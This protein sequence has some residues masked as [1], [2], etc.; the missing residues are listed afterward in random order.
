MTRPTRFVVVCQMGICRS[1]AL[2]LALREQGQDA[3]AISVDSRLTSHRMRDML[4]KW[5]D[6]VVFMQAKFADIITNR[7]LSKARVVDVGEDRWSNPTHPELLGF[8]R[9]VVADWK[10][11]RFD[12]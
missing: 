6:Y 5:A 3:V 4:F 11:R 10:N 8:C 12:I 2:V 9:G 1:G 7:Y